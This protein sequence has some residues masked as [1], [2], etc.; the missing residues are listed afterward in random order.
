[1]F[2]VHTRLNHGIFNLSLRKN[3]KSYVYFKH[4]KTIQTLN[5]DVS[6]QFRIPLACIFDLTIIN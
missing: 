3:K 1:M 4:V 6:R 2:K 5:I